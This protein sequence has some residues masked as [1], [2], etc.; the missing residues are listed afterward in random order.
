V[1]AEVEAE[2]YVNS[3]EQSFLCHKV[4]ISL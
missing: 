4:Y 2:N 3:I 1:L